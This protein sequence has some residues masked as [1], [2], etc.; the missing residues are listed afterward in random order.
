MCACLETVQ[1]SAACEG[2]ERAMASLVTS[3]NHTLAQDLLKREAKSQEV[4]PSSLRCLTLMAD[5]I[6]SLGARNCR[7]WRTAG[8][9]TQG[10][11]VVKA[12]SAFAA[13][14]LRIAASYGIRRTLRAERHL[15]RSALSCVLPVRLSFCISRTRLVFRVGVR[16]WLTGADSRMGPLDALAQQAHGTSPWRRPEWE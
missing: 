8:A 13:C 14:E 15:T 9:C 12:A 7:G 11:K 16:A 1:K 3:I 2:K 6:T 10:R 4:F 5:A